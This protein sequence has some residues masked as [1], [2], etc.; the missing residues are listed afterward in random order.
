MS[1]PVVHLSRRYRL[2][3]SHR[4][5]APAL[6]DRQNRDLYGKCNNP[7]GHGHTYFIEVTVAG[8][9]SEDT[10]FVVSLPR[11]DALVKIEVLDRFDHT[12]LNRD[13]TF[14]GSF[15]PST[16]NFATEIERVLRTRVPRLNT[17]GVLRFV[18]LRIEE[19]RN[20]AFDMPSEGVFTQKAL[21]DRSSHTA[22]AA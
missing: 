1:T 12:H 20:N 7:H 9:V 4:L 6:T 11:L 19:T 15:V 18:N 3:A 2:S 10:G 16:E 14:S 8:P 13:E 5:H 22:R 21:V 17:R